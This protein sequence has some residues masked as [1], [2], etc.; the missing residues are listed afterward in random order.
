MFSRSFCSSS[1]I[2]DRQ[3]PANERKKRCSGVKPSIFL[4]RSSGCF[5]ERLLQRG[6]SE[7]HSADVRDVFALGQFAIHV[8]A[9]QRFVFVVLIDDRFAALLVFVGRFLRPPIGQIADL[10]VLPALIVEAV[11]HFMADHAPIPP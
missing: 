1:R 5:V 3:I 6:V 11:R 4:L 10:V 2:F 9:R 7:F 8:Q